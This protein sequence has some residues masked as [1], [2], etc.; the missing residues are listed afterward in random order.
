MNLVLK[1]GTLIDGTGRVVPDAVVATAGSRIVAAGPAAEVRLPED[2]AEVIDVRGMTIMP[3]LID[4]HV[5][6]H[7]QALPGEGSRARLLAESDA[8]QAV[9]LAENA[10][11]TLEAGFTTIREMG[12]PNDINVDLTRAVRDGILKSPRIIPVCTVDMTTLPGGY[13]VHGTRGGNVT[14]PVEARRAARQKIA[15]GA[16]VIHVIATGAQYGQFGPKT[17][18]LTEEE[19]RGAI[20]EAHKLGKL[21]TANACSA[22]GAKAAVLAGTQCVEH[23]EYLCDD[24][25]LFKLMVDRG[26]AFV[27][28]LI[29]VVAKVEKIREAHARG[30][31]PALAPTVVE[32]TLDELEPH[33]RTF[34]MA[35]EAGVIMPMGSDAG[36]P[37]IP[38]G[39]GNARELEL[40][41]RY[42]ATPTQAIEAT[43]RVAAEVL[44]MDDR[45][46]TVTP[47]KE[48]DLI[49]VAEDPLRD[50][51][52]L[53][54][55]E[56]IKLVIQSGQIV[57]NRRPAANGA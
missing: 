45:I 53:Q 38:N 1:N 31:Q 51:R 42:G 20:E 21:T 18:I 40:Y 39:V 12:A 43:T 13:D 16:E 8:Y 44:R 25:D 29:V 22:P 47:D 49:V 14:G 2:G 41:V 52:V 24:P 11:R 6:L 48:A 5:H 28:T 37:Y 9:V 57:V 36:S 10:R 56:N 26:V 50:I 46:G 54:N 7:G 35:L 33:R 27:P 23:G 30:E 19:M 32:R 15:A 4:L 17:Q 34:E 55:H 3:G